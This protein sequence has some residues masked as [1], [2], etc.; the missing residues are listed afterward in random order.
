LVFNFDLQRDIHTSIKIPEPVWFENLQL[1]SPE[2]YEIV[3]LFT[4]DCNIVRS[5]TQ[6]ITTT[7]V[8]LY[9]KACSAT[10]FELV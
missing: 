8:P 6:N 5:S 2:N 10:V 9:L 3:P 4:T 1:G 7:G